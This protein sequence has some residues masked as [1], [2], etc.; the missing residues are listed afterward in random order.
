MGVVVMV[1]LLNRF[2]FYFSLV[3]AG[4]VLYLWGRR[5][6]R[7]FLMS[8]EKPVRYEYRPL[9]LPETDAPLSIARP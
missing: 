3:C 9:A 5:R 7:R 6:W 4:L 8:R 2:D 1:D